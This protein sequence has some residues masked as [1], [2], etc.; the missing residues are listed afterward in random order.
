MMECRALLGLKKRTNLELKTSQLGSSL[1]R[2][3]SLAG[4][5]AQPGP[6]LESA[7]W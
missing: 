2:K 7:F 4:T 5:M 1:G 6:C 3:L